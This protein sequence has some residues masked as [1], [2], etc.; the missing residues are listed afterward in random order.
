MNPDP[1]QRYRRAVFCGEYPVS[2]LQPQYAV[3]VLDTLCATCEIIEGPGWDIDEHAANK[4]CSLACALHRIL[5]ATFPF[6]YGPVG[7]AILRQFREDTLE[8]NLSITCAAETPR[9]F[10]PVLIATVNT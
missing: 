10:F 2:F 9:A 8:V 5:D 3:I 6:K 1:R 4:L 7:V